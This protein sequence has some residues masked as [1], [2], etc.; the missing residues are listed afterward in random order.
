M[1]YILVKEVKIYD[2]EI[3]LYKFSLLTIVFSELMHY[4]PLYC[5]F[6]IHNHDKMVYI[7]NKEV[8]IYDGEIA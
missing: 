1:V 3:A 8:K 4:T 2:G 7:L 5:I 6:I